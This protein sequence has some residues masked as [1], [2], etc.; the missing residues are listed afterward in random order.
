MP[1]ARTPNAKA[2]VSGVALHDPQR[3][4]NRKGPK[5]TFPLGEP[6]ARMSKDEKAA[7]SEFQANLPWLTRAHRVLVRSACVLSA[8][9][10]TGEIGVSALHALSSILSKLGATPVDETKVNHAEDDEED[11]A[12]EFFKH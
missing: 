1:R 10:D 3:F 8:K 12:D 9:M 6:Y 11:P 7:W 2:A 5:R 4:K